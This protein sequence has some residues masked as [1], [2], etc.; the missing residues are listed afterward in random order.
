MDWRSIT[1]DWN[2]A[3]AFFITAEEG[4]LSA[5]A[6]ALKVSQ[7]TLGRQV[8][9]LE[10]ELSVTLFEKVGRKLEITPSGLGLI[11][12]VRAMSEAANKLNLAATGQ[13]TD[14]EGTVS[15]TASEAIAVMILPTLLE[16]LRKLEPGI[17]FEIIASN[18]SSDL[19]RREADIAIRNFQP[20][21][22]ELIAKKLPTI[23]ASL[24]ATPD[25]LRSIGQPTK[26]AALAQ[27]AFVGFVDNANYLQGLNEMGLPLTE[28]NFPFATE[29]HMTHWELVKA[30]AAVGV[31]P[32]FI[33]DQ[34]PLVTRLSSD[35]ADFPVETWLVVH[36]ELR[37]TLRIQK[38][39]RFLFD[40]LSKLFKSNRVKN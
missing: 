9:A 24:Y 1:F 32:Q 40:E 27:A 33:G 5:A 19:R 17:R 25:Y 34:E 26:S 18:A 20:T 6:R 36:R 4:S 14:L 35:I 28:A 37:T 23:S 13:T 21:H 39:Y 7:S 11:E 29:S 38:V 8:T 2:R 16:R 15:I 22:A 10:K 3:R 31:M 12:H 30:G